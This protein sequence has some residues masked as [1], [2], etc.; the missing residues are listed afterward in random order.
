MKKTFPLHVPGKQD[1][2]VLEAI[3]VEL[4]KYVKRERK[5][6]LPPEM[7]CWD[8][9]CRIGSS[10]EAA[11]PVALPDVSQSVDAVALAGSDQVYVEIMAA[12]AHRERH[13]HRA[14]ST[15]EE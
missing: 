6:T 7:T 3:K 10:L 14:P 13:S 4:A 1:A 9:E 8:F 15:R 2:R 5:K 12:A 11:M